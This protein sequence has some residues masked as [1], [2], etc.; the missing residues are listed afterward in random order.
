MI[1]TV[2]L[3]SA[4]DR[5]LFIDEFQPGTTM[6]P[7]KVIESVG[8]KGFDTSVVLQTLGVANLALGFVAGSI[9]RCLVDLLAGYGLSHDL[10]WVEGETRTAYVLVET[11]RHRHT[12]LITAG[13]SVSPAGYQAL[14]ERY[15]LHLNKATWVVMGGSLAAGVPVSSYRHL[16]ELAQ[17]ARVP[18]LVDSFAE[19]LL[20]TL[21]VR[22]AIL[23]MNQTEFSR[24]FGLQAGSLEDLIVSAQALRRRHH[25]PALVLTCGAA[26]ILAF[27][28]KASYR[29]T[30]PPQQAVNA[31]GAGDGVS[32]ALAWRLSLG[33][34]WPDALRWAAAVGAAVVLTE[35]TADCRWA[36]IEHLL[37]QTE[38]RCL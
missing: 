14:L 16:V 35:G 12:H 30:A 10:I 18:A 15:R 2:T 37:G 25:L 5:V 23:K 7:Q 36:D 21:P 28:P 3:N 27:T 38:V 9:G 32:A 24:T 11:R 31:A 22:P 33:A 17:Q 4:L 13:L 34:N 8:G 1:L 26:G 6:H 19:P 20:A 29:A